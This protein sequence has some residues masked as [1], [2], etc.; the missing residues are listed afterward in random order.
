MKGKFTPVNLK[1]QNL[2]ILHVPIKNREVWLKKG[3]YW[4]SLKVQI[5]LIS[6]LIIIFSDFANQ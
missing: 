4:D 3:G 5:Y 1:F 2:D 6:L